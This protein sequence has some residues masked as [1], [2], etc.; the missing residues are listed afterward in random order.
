MT[1]NNNKQRLLNLFADNINGEITAGTLRDFIE[2]I[3]DDKEENIILFDSLEAFE[4]APAEQREKIYEGSF[5]AITNSSDE[6]N[7]LYL[8]LMNQPQQREF[9]KQISSNSKLS[10]AT[11]NYVEYT[12]QDGQYLFNVEYSDNLVE[13]YV[14]GNKRPASRVQLNST[15]TNNGTSVI[16]LDPAFAGQ[17]VEI[18][19]T[20]L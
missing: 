18:R 3:F 5:V 14:D 12:A 13:V 2:T 16:L 15:P 4:Y 6:E 7:G 20:V 19:A 10:K 1:N 11:V 17:L 9:L 8:S